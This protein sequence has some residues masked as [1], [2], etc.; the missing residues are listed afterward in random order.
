MYLVANRLTR[1]VIAAGLAMTAFASSPAVAQEGDAGEVLFIRAGK[2]VVRP[3]EVIEI[4]TLIRH[5]MESGFRRDNRGQL[6]A[7]DILTAFSCTYAGRE[8]FRAEFFPAIAANPLLSFFLVATETG[9]LEF[10][11]TDQHGEMQNA[12]S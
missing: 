8:V 7:R 5:R 9:M 2:V 4:K 6:V 11:W 12:S 10:R 1:G 3:G